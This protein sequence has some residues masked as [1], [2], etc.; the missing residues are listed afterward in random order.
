VLGVEGDFD[1]FD[2]C[3]VNAEY[4]AMP[5]VLFIPSAEIVQPQSNIAT[6]G[7]PGTELLDQE[8]LRTLRLPQNYTNSLP[9]FSYLK[10]IFFGFGRKC[11]SLGKTRY[12]FGISDGKWVELLNYK[13]DLD[14]HIIISDETVF[15]GNSG[16][17]VICLDNCKTYRIL[18]KSNQ[19]WL[20]VEFVGIHSG[21][22]FVNCVDC[23]HILPERRK[24][25]PPSDLKVCHSC[26]MDPSR[27]KISLNYNYS[28]SVHHPDFV[29]CY[30]DKVLPCLR[31]LFPELPICVQRYINL[32]A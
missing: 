21:G 14:T 9:P 1:L 6:L 17:P 15:F 8:L 4:P 31:K 25:Q 13:A 18:D 24:Y 20:L 22:E 23:L 3:L 10:D 5:K 7:F 11:V 16:G 19:E 28:L 12:P 29:R 32:H 30:K 26:R 27:K 2:F